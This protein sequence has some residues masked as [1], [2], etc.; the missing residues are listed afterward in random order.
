[1]FVT[2]NLGGF[3][4]VIDPA[5]DTVTATLPTGPGRCPV[6]CPW[7]ARG[8]GSIGGDAMAVIDTLLGANMNAIAPV[9]QSFS[10][11]TTDG[12]YNAGRTVNV[13]ATFGSTVASGSTMTVVLN[14]GAGVVLGT[15]AGTT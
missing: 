9:L 10:S 13:T 1:M 3:S 14:T 6:R 2:N 7:L 15:I 5:T 8:Y 11:T 12:N 4:S